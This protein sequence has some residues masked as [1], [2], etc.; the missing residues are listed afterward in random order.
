MRITADKIFFVLSEDM[1]LPGQML[2]WCALEQ[3]HFFNEF[4][5]EGVNDSH[6]EIVLKFSP[7][8]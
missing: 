8:Q 1:G 4:T 7:G 2:S 5:M 3:A 6:N